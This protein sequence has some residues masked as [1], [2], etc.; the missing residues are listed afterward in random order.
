MGYVLGMDIGTTTTEGC[1]VDLA[2][3]RPGPRCAVGYAPGFASVDGIPLSAEQPSKV[4]SDAAFRVLHELVAGA[5]KEDAA[6]EAVAISSMVGGLNIPVDRYFTPLRNV[7]MWLDQRATMEAEAARKALDVEGLL[8]VTGNGVVTPYFGFVKLLWYMAHDTENFRRTHALETPNGMVVRHLTGEHVWD[9][10]ALGAFGGVL[11][12]ASEKVDESLLGRL[13]R[14]GSELAGEDLEVSP[15]LFGRTVRPDQVVG[16]VNGG[17][18][19]LSGLPE[20]IPVVASGVDAPIALM[21]S[22]GRAPGDNTLMMGTSWVLGLLSGRGADRPMPGMVHMPHVLGGDTLVFSMTG[23]PYTGGSA[24][25][26]MPELVTRASFSDLE[27]EAK[28]VPAGSGG[29]VFLPYLMGDRM[30]IGSPT[31]TGAFMGLRA[32]HNR[33]HLFR[34][35]LEGGAYLHEVCLGEA[36]RAGVELAATRLVDGVYRSTLWRHIV[37]DVSGRRVL[38]IPDFPGTSFGDAMLAAIVTD[39]VAEDRAFRWLPEM[40]FTEPTVDPDKRSAYAEAR[41]RFERYRVALEGA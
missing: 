23:G 36:E 18:A 20:G 21:A 38:Y 8:E 24:G 5:A 34:A 30:P 26:W 40:R 39:K 19:G 14:V 35:V 28:L 11:D 10:S 22:G 15:S 27:R 9:T 16:M 32:D 4:W 12:V 41:E 37:A 31:A 25:F 17:G 33:G 1:L 7:P 3:G 13:S 6:I 2:T 29:V